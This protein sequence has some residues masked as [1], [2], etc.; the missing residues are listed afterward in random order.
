L[1]EEVNVPGL[2]GEPEVPEQ[3]APPAEPEPQPETEEVIALRFKGEEHYVPKRLI[4]EL[5]QHL[6]ADEYTSVMRLQKAWDADR[7]YNES[8]RQREDFERREADYN[9]R[10]QA[11]EAERQQRYGTPQRPAQQPAEDDPI[12]IL[13]SLREE[14]G[15]VKQAWETERAQLKAAL[16]E[17]YKIDQGAQIQA[18]YNQMVEKI[19]ADPRGL[20]V[21]PYEEIEREA[22]ESGLAQNK[23]L[24]WNQVLER[25]YRNLAWDY[26]PRAVEKQTLENLRKPKATVTVPGGRSAPPAPKPPSPT[27]A[28][29][30]MSL[31][32]SIDLMPEKRH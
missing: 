18:A 31:R 14:F 3:I 16:E 2:T 12:A 27:D 7:I 30:G 10:M 4:S 29:A 1:P 6:G 17:Q 22:I 26:V 8:Q 24:S 20:P 32:D 21:I 23:R 19:K 13:R 5:G 9:A 11:L 15:S 28:L 25:S